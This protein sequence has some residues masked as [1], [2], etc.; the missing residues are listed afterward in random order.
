MFFIVGIIS[1]KLAFPMQ[2]VR[3]FILLNVFVW[4]AFGC[5]KQADFLTTQ[6]IAHAGAGLHIES[7]PYHDD[8]KEAVKYAMQ[9]GGIEAV[10]VDIQCSKN[11]TPWLFHDTHLEGETNGNGCVPSSSDEEL[12][13]LRYTGLKNQALA[14]LIELDFIPTEKTL[15][16]D[17]RSYDN[18]AQ[19]LVNVDS[20]IVS[21]K[22]VLKQ[23]NNPKVKIIVGYTNWILPMTQ[24]GWDVYA[25][26]NDIRSY[27]KLEHYSKSAGICI[28]NDNV[29]ADEVKFIHSNGKQ[30]IIFG[31]RSPKGTRSALKKHPDYL[32]VDDLNVALIEKYP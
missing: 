31:V 12:L 23:L 2:F 6:L 25:Q 16:L 19:E 5:R 32:M 10:E 27:V 8:S 11:G 15:F 1:L 26:T 3:T 13:Q 17:V 28:P 24:A 30:M 14:R 22:T 4:L 9:L 21:L 20:L 7:S 29:T 18:C